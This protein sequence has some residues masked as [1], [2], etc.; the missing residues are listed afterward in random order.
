MPEGSVLGPLFLIYINDL[1]L[2]LKYS[3]ACHFAD[4]TN[5][6]LSDSSQETLAE[7]VNYD[8]RK[9]SMWLGANKLSLNIEKTELVVFW[10]QSTK[11]NNP[12]KIKLNGKRLFPTSSVKYLG[13]LLHEH[14]MCSPQISHVQMKLN[15]AVGK[16]TKLRYQANI[17]ILKTIYHSL[18]ETHLIYVCQLGQNNKETQKKFRTL[19]NRALKKIAFKR[20]YESADPLYKNLKTIKFQYLL[21][22]NNCLFMC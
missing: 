19:Q 22:L 17:H 7:R 16:L 10:R 2:C 20:Q 5:I 13:V 9:L 14:L 21:C 18:F 12:F 6:T 15:Q 1:H 11:L 8:L 3:K 4:N